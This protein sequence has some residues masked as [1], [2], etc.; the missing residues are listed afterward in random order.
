MHTEIH[1]RT[2]DELL[3]S[4]R[5]DF[6]TFDLEGMIGTQELIKVAQRVNADL[7]LRIAMPRSKI[8]E[9]KNGKAKLPSDFHVL[10]SVTI[11]E[12]RK[13]TKP[14]EHLR[15][16]TDG[17]LEG[18]M[19]SKMFNISHFTI[20]RD[21]VPGNNVIRHG[22]N[23]ENFLVQAFVPD[24]TML[25]FEIVPDGPDSLII[26]NRSEITVF[27]VKVVVFGAALRTGE[28]TQT[29]ADITRCED[30]PYH[31]CVLRWHD[32]K[33]TRYDKFSRME[34]VRNRNTGP[35]L[36]TERRDFNKGYLK[37]GFL[38]TG[39]DEGT[40]LINFDSL[41]E[42]EDGNLLVMDHPIVNE[43]YEYALKQRILEN[44]LMNGEE[45]T[46]RLN[47][48]EVRLRASRNNALSYVNMPDFAELKK[49]T[50][51]NRKAM[52]HRFYKMFE[53]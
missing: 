10:N 35:T 47:L 53:S 27:N 30:H 4:V 9:V 45:V 12:G 6:R 19:R 31:P 49:I 43:Y 2:F 7:G 42:D 20:V 36:E 50:E 14:T 18:L 29:D 17:L 38:V 48:V 23:T 24:G 25:D 5:G 21:I 34:I 26:I 39:F 46:N 37:N 3:D 44:M 40:V 33:I 28:F 16:Y 22:L 51:M 52:Y 32:H 8:L 11:C 13:V 15:T 41:M 1:Y